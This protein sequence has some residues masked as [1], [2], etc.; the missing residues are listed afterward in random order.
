MSRT[1]DAATEPTRIDA[2]TRH[3]AVRDFF[4]THRRSWLD[5]YGSN[6]FDARNYRRRSDVALAFLKQVPPGSRKLLDVGCGA[7]VQ[8]AAAYQLGWTVFATDFTLELLCQAQEEFRTPHWI[9]ATAEELPFP[10]GTFDAIVMLGVI[11]YVS[12]PTTVLRCMRALLVPQGHLIVSWAHDHPLLES[13]SHAVSALPDRLYGAAKRWLVDSPAAIPAARA[14][15][16]TS[17]NRF[18]SHQA[19]TSLVTGA[20]FTMRQ[21][22]SVNFGQFRFMDY[23]LWPERVDALVSA[24]LERAARIPPLEWL[25]QFSRTHIALVQR[26]G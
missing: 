10:E 16:Y 23:P 4:A 13:V 5:R 17:Y 1:L 19:F 18:W 22:R 8:A 25:G 12:D 20:G 14:G 7:G 24:A 26:S 6:S 9:S 15:F 3:T 2:R 21:T 11:G